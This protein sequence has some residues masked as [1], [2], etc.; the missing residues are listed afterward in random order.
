MA[1][2]QR[3]D[4]LKS[5]PTVTTMIDPRWGEP[6]PTKKAKSR[7]SKT[8]KSKKVKPEKPDPEPAVAKRRYRK[9]GVL[10]RFDSHRPVGKPK[11][12][13]LHVKAVTEGRTLY[14]KTRCDPDHHRILKSGI[15]SRKIGNKIVKG[16]W[17]GMPIYTL[18]LEERA[19]CPG[20]CVHWRSCYGNK[21]HRAQRFPAGVETEFGIAAELHV[22]NREHRRT[23]FAVRL[24]V[25]GDFYSV[26]YVEFWLKCLKRFQRLRVFGFTSWPPDTDIGK[27]I[28][29]ARQKHWNRFAIRTS[30]AGL[31]KYGA[32][33]LRVD[34]YGEYINPGDAGIVCPAQTEKTDCCGTCGLCWQTTSN[35]A[36]LEH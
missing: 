19:T 13:G 18:T 30:N 15:N 22:L 26:E 21:M 8:A 28:V 10:R 33:T 4:S 7:K 31:P 34:G 35:I 11:V 14:P 24:H 36:F 32:T 17:M 3:K 1:T 23:G 27:A 20:T 12:L 16:K 25:L 6:K 9:G 5:G 2:E 29:D